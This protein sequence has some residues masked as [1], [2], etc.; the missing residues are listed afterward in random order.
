MTGAAAGENHVPLDA[1]P[2]SI[3]VTDAQ[4]DPP[5]PLITFANQAFVRLTG[6]ELHE[7]L[8]RSPRFLQGPRTSRT[9][10]D[11]LRRRL[12][13]GREFVGETFNYR[14]DGSEFVMQWRVAALPDADGR[15]RRYIAVQRDVTELRRL[16]TIAESTSSSS[17]FALSFAVLRH[18]LGNPVN[19][20]KVAL[21]HLRDTH[22][23]FSAEQIDGYL[24]PVSDELA[25]IE[26]LLR[27]LRDFAVL[28]ELKLAPTELEPLVG[29]LVRLV[30]PALRRRGIRLSSSVAVGLPAPHLDP[31]ALTQVLLNLINNAADATEGRARA[32]IDVRVGPTLAA[33]LEI[34]VRDNGRG[35]T[36]E[37]LER[38]RLPF[39]TTKARGTGL[40]LAVVERLVARMN[41][42]L[43]LESI[44]GGGTTA[45]MRFGARPVAGVTGVTQLLRRE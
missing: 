22:R 24:D 38:A 19:S 40:G 26:H 1:V 3:L 10:L 6:Y 11:E 29:D 8:G 9:V 7:V 45:R 31:G 18:E 16:Q 35:M 21:K 17:N 4:L 32:G 15:I 5:G 34:T 39:Y 23:S 30:E 25:R 44:P 28:D 12:V 27:A 2:E 43:E 14:K 20:I 42:V 41:G 36:A 33:L 37:Q 13:D